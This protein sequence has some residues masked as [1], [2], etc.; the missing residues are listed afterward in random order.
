MKKTV[1][2]GTHEPQLENF[3]KVQ[4][5]RRTFNEKNHKHNVLHKSILKKRKK[6]N[7]LFLMPCNSVSEQI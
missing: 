1:E 3:G 4:A 6:R 2:R 5:L 7:P